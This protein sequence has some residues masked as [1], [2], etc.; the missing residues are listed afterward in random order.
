MSAVSP[1]EK[2]LAYQKR[3]ANTYAIGY[4]QTIDGEHCS[5]TPDETVVHV[6][7]DMTFIN[8]SELLFLTNFEEEFTYLASFDINSRTF[9]PLQKID[10]EAIL[11]LKWHT[12]TKTAYLVTEKGVV[13]HLYAYQL[14][15]KTLEA[16]DLPVD[17]VQQL[18]VSK[19][20]NLYVLGRSVTSSFNLYKKEAN[21]HD[22]E[23]LT[24]NPVPGIAKEDLVDPEVMTYP[25]FDGMP[26]E[27]LLFQPKETVANGYT[28]FWPHGGPQS[29][30]RKWFRGACQFLLGQ[31]YQIFAPNFRGSTGYGA[32]FA[33]LV[34]RDWGEGPRLDC[35]AGIEWL[36]EQGLAEL[37]NSLIHY[38]RLFLSCLFVFNQ[39]AI[40]KL[41]DHFL[42]IT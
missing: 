21:S 26:I 20:G 27:A 13:D 36:F 19:Q 8:D 41:A 9:I 3:F 11:S 10:R 5:L 17:T 38:K 12:A 40:N 7:S 15:S 22:W 33:K 42:G 29:A 35:V 18:H 34:E 14:E 28:I 39:R 16:L 32:S 23:N 4:C 24:A 37:S 31:G 25:S 30:E 6:T 1:N 2:R